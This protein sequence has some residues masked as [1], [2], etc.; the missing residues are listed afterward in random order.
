MKKKKKISN[1]VPPLDL[2]NEPSVCDQTWHHSKELK[3]I[4]YA[5]QETHR[6]N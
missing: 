6:L 2:P 1:Y 3:K 5:D 4:G